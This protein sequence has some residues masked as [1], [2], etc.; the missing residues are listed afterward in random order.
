MKKQISS[1]TKSYL[2]LRILRKMK[3]SPEFKAKVMAMADKR[4][5]QNYLS[6]AH[7]ENTEAALKQIG[8]WKSSTVDS[9]KVISQMKTNSKDTN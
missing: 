8:E 4:M 9:K 1:S 2:R 7:Q 3:K 5:G 6:K